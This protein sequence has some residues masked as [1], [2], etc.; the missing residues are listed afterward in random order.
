MSIKRT[1][2]VVV[3]LS[4]GLFMAGCCNEEK[5]KSNHDLIKTAEECKIKYP[6]ICGGMGGETPTIIVEPSSSQA[7]LHW[8]FEGTPQSPGDPLL[9]D[10]KLR[11]DFFGNWTE[12]FKYLEKN[13]TDWI[14]AKDAHIIYLK[15]DDYTLKMHMD[16]NDRMVYQ[17]TTNSSGDICLMTAGEDRRTG[18]VPQ[19]FTNFPSD[20]IEHHAKD[21]T[22][23]TAVQK[24]KIVTYER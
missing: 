20:K 18:K 16:S 11:A 12:E 19:E 8:T 22:V 2:A 13:E 21:G 15:S 9:P 3:I 23:T 4:F 17:M 7:L 14:N 5:C 10:C 6:D 24:V 1:V